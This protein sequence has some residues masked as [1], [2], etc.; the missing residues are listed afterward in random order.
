MT[1]DRPMWNK[2]TY[3]KFWILTYGYQ[4]SLTSVELGIDACIRKWTIDLLKKVFFDMRMAEAY[5]D[6]CCTFQRLFRQEGERKVKDS[7]KTLLSPRQTKGGNI[8]W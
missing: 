3:T 5:T 7:L 2:L 4:M 8:R 6:E 1:D